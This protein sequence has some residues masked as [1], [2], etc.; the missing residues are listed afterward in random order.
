MAG[1]DRNKKAKPGEKDAFYA[2]RYVQEPALGLKL[3]AG[4][5][6]A[7]NRAEKHEVDRLADKLISS[8]SGLSLAHSDDQF[9]K[10]LQIIHLLKNPLREKVLHDCAIIGVAGQYS[11]GKSSLINSLV[12]KGQDDRTV[13]PISQ[14]PATSVPAYLLKGEQ[15][16]ITACTSNGGERIID[17]DQ[18]WALSHAF[19]KA[20]KINPAQ[21]IDFVAIEYPAFPVDGI[22][23][24][25]TPGFDKSDQAKIVDFA[26]RERTKNALKSADHLIWLINPLAATELIT[27]DIEFIK[28]IR[29][30][31][32]LTIIVNKAKTKAEIGI[33][34][35]P[36]NCM[37]LQHIRNTCLENNIRVDNMFAYEPWDPDWNNGCKKL[38][39]ILHGA[40]KKNKV[41]R[42]QELNEC[43]NYIEKEISAHAK[44]V[45][46][47]DIKDINKL[48]DQSFNPLELETLVEIRG[49]MG[50]QRININRAKDRFREYSRDIKRWAKKTTAAA[51]S[52]TKLKTTQKI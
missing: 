36:D 47:K 15:E 46:V 32:Q 48:A 38:L 29:P 9:G 22:A 21:F 27:E 34:Q 16:K 26:D 14:N 8:C 10:I 5:I 33:S 25:D 30:T 39:S 44:G 13:L 19:A 28:E 3:L 23:L 11:T 45:Y 37:E 18:L 49:L 2:N 24:L 51:Q 41:I 20:Y 12:S 43:L 31:G 17:G 6:D 42:E 4:L 52:L 35:E 7:H 50:L 1:F 40:S